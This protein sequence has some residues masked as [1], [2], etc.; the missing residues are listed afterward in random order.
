M[1]RDLSASAK[2]A[3]DANEVNYHLLISAEWPAQT[4]RIWN[5][6]G[7]LDYL[8]NTYQG[9]GDFIKFEFPSEDIDAIAQGATAYLM[10]DSDAI[11][12]GVFDADLSQPYQGGRVEAFIGFKQAGTIDYIPLFAGIL[13]SDAISDDGKIVTLTLKAENRLAD[14]LRK[15]VYRYNS[16]SQRDLTGADDKFF[17]FVESQQTKELTW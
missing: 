12:G 13:D 1:S 11:N 4:V 16:Q 14:L 8:G 15:R 9:T 5:G 6:Y 10:I 3:I 2:T 7:T 17:D